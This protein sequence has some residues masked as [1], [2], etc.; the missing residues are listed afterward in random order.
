MEGTVSGTLGNFVLGLLVIVALAVFGARARAVEGRHEQQGRQL[1]ETA[2]T[3]SV[4]VP[5]RTAA[6]GRPW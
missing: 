6:I 4:P 1:G 2:H 5:V 3:H